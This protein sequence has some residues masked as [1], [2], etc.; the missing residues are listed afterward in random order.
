MK[1]H[2]SLKYLTIPALIAGGLVSCSDDTEFPRQVAPE[3]NLP[4]ILSATYPTLTRA[5]DAGFEQD[6]L[7]GVY[8][9]DY[10]GET[11]E[12]I[13]GDC[14][15]SNVQYRFNGSNNE[16]IG[17][18]DIYWTSAETP[19]DI[20]AYYPFKD[21]IDDP[22]S[23]A[24]S[25]ERR[26]NLSGDETS[27]GGYE[28]SDL[29]RAKASK[30]MPTA[31][32]I[33]LT[34]NHLMSG[35][36]IRLERGE[37]FSAEEWNSLDKVAVISNIQ[38]ETNVNLESGEVT[39]RPSQPISVTPLEYNGEW[40]GVVPPQTLAAGQA[41]I[42]VSVD[43]VGYDLK[44][45]Q[46]LTL[47]QGK[48]HI[49]TI[50]VNKRSSSGDFEFVADDMS[51]TDWIDETDFRE[52]IMR[53]YVVVEVEEAG[54][55]EKA[56]A[57]AGYKAEEVM[58][59]K[60]KGEINEKDFTF[61]R[62]RCSVLKS[63]NLYECEVYDRGQRGHIPEGALS[64]KGT[65]THILWPAY[66]RVINQGAF[67]ETGLM[68][69]LILPEGLTHAGTDPDLNVTPSHW[70]NAWGA[71]TNCFSLVGT[72]SL[73]STLEFIGAG[74]F[75]RTGLTGDLLIP[76]KVKYIAGCAFDGS[77]FTGA[78]SLPSGLTTMGNGAFAGVPLSGTL[79]IPQG[80]KRIKDAC[81]RGCQ[82]DLLVLPEGLEAIEPQA[83]SGCRIK[84][85]LKLPSTLK[86]LG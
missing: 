78:L 23:M 32:R 77:S 44:K 1:F 29:L 25:I 3:G 75:C 81:F 83:F 72:L 85:E 24:F 30:V 84:G 54:G 7:M 55:L 28:A 49:F 39:L 59:L 18:T 26:Q 82:F 51:I 31:N 74:A 50:T 4:V 57:E 61:M 76:E 21:A 20:V 65:L 63:L 27:I 80:M 47:K 6:D 69:D 79:R 71:F 34:L 62:E 67:F 38:P 46:P 48:L 14:H 68:G 5:S 16:W 37:G 58:N 2:I 43:G 19:A 9:M 64:G 35:V 17:A 36:R 8:I 45:D 60:I 10:S 12:D 86:E 73:P 52:G 41:V 33:D 15:A 70:G 53:Q 40:R 13:S 66:L 42:S 56:I 11:P 22:K